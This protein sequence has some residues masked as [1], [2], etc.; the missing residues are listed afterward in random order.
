MKAKLS[1]C[2]I[3]RELAEGCHLA[4]IVVQLV[5]T[6]LPGVG[7]EGCGCMYDLEIAGAFF[8]FHSWR[9]S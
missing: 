5:D 4:V 3:Y 8:S 7:V 6:A 9:W 2:T 1:L